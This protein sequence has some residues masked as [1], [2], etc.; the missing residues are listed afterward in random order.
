MKKVIIAKKLAPLV[1]QNISLLSRSDIKI[2]TA[3][4][5]DEILNI[6]IE[7]TVDLIVTS[8]DQ[9]G[10]SSADIFSIFRQSQHLK[11][12][13]V[14]MLCENDKLHQDWCKQC[15]AH[16][17]LVEP[18]DS[19]VLQEKV[20]QF[21]NVATRKAYRVTLNISV[22]GKFRNRPFLCHLEDLSVTG[23]LIRAKLDL[24]LGDRISCSFYLPEG[25]QVNILASVVRTVKQAGSP[26]RHYGIHY[27]DIPAETKERIES[28]ITKHY[29]K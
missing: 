13:L 11:R 29:R 12:V 16:A 7:E 19:R 14:I 26:E 15:G 9:P 24:E 2:F 10:T 5:T 27:I 3:A 1:L 23:A 20:Q 22:E 28:Y 21:L 4:T 8:R 17:I 6:H 18:V 25:A